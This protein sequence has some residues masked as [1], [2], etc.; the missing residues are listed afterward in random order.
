MRLDPAHARS[1][2]QLLHSGQALQSQRCVQQMQEEDLG[3]R[4]AVVVGAGEGYRV[5]SGGERGLHSWPSA[6]MSPYAPVALRQA[7]MSDW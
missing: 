2:L 6:L 5:E 7:S 4:E 3:I 1:G